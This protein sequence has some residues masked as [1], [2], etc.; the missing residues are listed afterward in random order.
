MV[1]PDW[2]AERID[3]P[4]LDLVPHHGYRARISETTT[5]HTVMN[6]ATIEEVRM[7]ETLPANAPSHQVLE[8]A[9]RAQRILH[10][11]VEVMAVLVTGL[12]QAVAVEV[13]TTSKPS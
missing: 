4:A 13:T 3:G 2:P 5:T 9:E 1:I 12:L 7:E 11:L 10:H 8:V 6:A